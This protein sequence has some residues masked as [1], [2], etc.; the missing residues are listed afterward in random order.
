MQKRLLVVLCAVQLVSIGFG[1]FASG[2]VVNVLSWTNYI[3]DRAIPDFEQ[4]TGI[5]VN[6][7]VM[8]SNDVLEGKLLAGNSGY[9]VVLPSGHFF[10][11]QIKAGLYQ[12]LDRTKLTRYGNLDPVLLARVEAFDPGNRYGVP[13][14]WG[15]SGVAYNANKIHERM[16]D[17]PVTSWRMLFDPAIV[18]RF[19]D[20]GVTLLDQGDEVLESALLYLGRDPNST[21]AEDLAAAAK[22]I[23]EVQKHVRYFHGTS[24]V[25]DLANGEI[26]LAMGWSGDVFQA[27]SNARPGV[28]IHYEIPEEGAIVWFDVMAIPA[29]ARNVDAAHAWI[30]HVLDAEVAAKITNAIHY[31]NA[32]LAS[33]AHITAEIRDNPDVYPPP[34][35]MSRLA[36]ATPKPQGYVR[37]RNRAWTQ[38]KAG[39]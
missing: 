17:A 7:D 18:A 1:V 22:V 13:Y 12:P 29:D 4:R 14:M 16:P 38:A 20:C 9:D 32:N 10:G 27:Q 33:R 24:W 23:R 30:D 21:S 39:R 3:D 26:C 5:K 37:A 25:D 15:T 6:Y 31:A 11:S 8:D 28:D 36:A 35:V 19:A 34:E 2:G